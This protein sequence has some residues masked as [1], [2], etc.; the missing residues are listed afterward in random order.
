MMMN[1]RRGFDRSQGCDSPAVRATGWVVVAMSWVTGVG[2]RKTLEGSIS[3]GRM[4]Y[5]SFVVLMQGLRWGSPPFRTQVQ[6]WW[7]AE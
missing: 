6:H 2:E 5:Y 3:S 1:P 7:G 4:V